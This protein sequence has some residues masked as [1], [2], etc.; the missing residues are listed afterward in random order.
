MNLRTL[1]DNLPLPILLVLI[2]ILAALARSPTRSPPPSTATP[3][4]TA[5]FGARSR[6]FAQRGAEAWLRNPP[7]GS[8]WA[9]RSHH[10]A[11]VHCLPVST[12]G[13]W[14]ECH[15]G[16]V[17]AAGMLYIMDCDTAEHNNIGCVSGR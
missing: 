13:R 10:N 2:G 16:P 7:P 11:R 3:T 14:A 1:N 5:C 4:P 6:A 15:I 9:T 17:D 8:V 12:D